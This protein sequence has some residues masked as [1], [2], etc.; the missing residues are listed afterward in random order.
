MFGHIVS[1]TMKH[2]LQSIGGSLSQWVGGCVGQWVDGLIAVSLSQIII[3]QLFFSL[4]WMV[5]YVT[6]KNTHPAMILLSSC[7]PKLGDTL[8]VEPD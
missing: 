1:A 5:V 7:L 2:I 8:L 6:G 3:P 4:L